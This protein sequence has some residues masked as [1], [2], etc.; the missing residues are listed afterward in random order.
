M[1]SWYLEQCY[2]MKFDQYKTDV[3]ILVADNCNF[4]NIDT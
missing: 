4:M 3:I 1:T 2:Y